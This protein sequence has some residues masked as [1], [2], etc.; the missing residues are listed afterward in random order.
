M[1]GFIRSSRFAAIIA[2]F[3]VASAC[4][5]V[6][7]SSGALD[8]PVVAVPDD[9][10]MLDDIDVIEIETNPNAPYSVKLWI[11]GSTDGLFIHAGDNR[12]TW[13]EHLEDDPRLRL[14]AHGTIYELTAER[15]LNQDTFAT[16][17][18]VYDAKYGSR[19]QNENVDEVYLY[20]LMAR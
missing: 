18:V 6:P 4:D 19:P 14:K 8:G 20:R 12:T 5:Y 1:N 9:W 17:M 11:V 7:F 3:V 15:V 16:F 2:V 10:S 13:V